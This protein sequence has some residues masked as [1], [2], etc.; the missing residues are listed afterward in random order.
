MKSILLFS[1]FLKLNFSNLLQFKLD[2]IS[3]DRIGF[4]PYLVYFSP[5]NWMKNVILQCQ[6]TVKFLVQVKKFC[7]FRHFV[8]FFFLF[9]QLF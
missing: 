9:I 4:L 6:K 5:Y 2:N 3:P 1:H 8:N 7:K